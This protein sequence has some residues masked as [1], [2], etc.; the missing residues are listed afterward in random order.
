MLLL[1]LGFGLGVLAVV[2]AD[3]A[4][5]RRNA[6][7][8]AFEDCDE[9]PD[10]EQPVCCGYSNWSAGYFVE[11][12]DHTFGKIFVAKHQDSTLK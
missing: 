10:G 11:A 9:P 8:F 5:K 1:S 7:A 4:D 6:Y 2:L 12:H 3:V